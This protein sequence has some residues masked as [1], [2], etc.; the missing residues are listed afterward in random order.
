M[1]DVSAP[2]GP[3]AGGAG[4]VAYLHDAK[5]D[6]VFTGS[7]TEGVMEINVRDTGGGR[8]VDETI[9]VAGF[10]YVHAYARYG[11]FDT[12]TLN[13]SPGDDTLVAKP[14]QT[15][16]YNVTDPDNMFYLR[17]KLFEEAVGNA[18]G[19]FDVAG[20]HDSPG[21][22]VFTAEPASAE[23]RAA[24]SSY[25]TVANSFEEVYGYATTG[26][27]EAHLFD[28]AFEDRLEADLPLADPDH[29]ATLFS[30][31][32]NPSDYFYYVRGFDTVDAWSTNLEDTTDVDDDDVTADWL[33]PHGW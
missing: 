3:A 19:G 6:D 22:D 31:G 12:A 23:M 28:S 14:T 15:R 20:M 2:N 21:D 16:L 33:V 26:T 24:D 25:R 18:S 4:D 7:P 10:G 27:D 8:T 29:W 13:D 1:I 9:T 32:T 30:T 5:N 17:A 11:G